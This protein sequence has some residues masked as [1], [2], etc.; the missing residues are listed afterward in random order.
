V[1]YG[2][3]D[4]TVPPENAER[5]GKLMKE[6]ENNCVLVPFEGRGH[7]FFNHPA[8][9]KR[10]KIEDFNAVIEKGKAFLDLNG[11]KP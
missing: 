10:N 1:F 3:Q 4:K 2:T 9:L 7:R 6:A 5:F 11:L 8:L